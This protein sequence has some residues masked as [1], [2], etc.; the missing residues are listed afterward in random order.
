MP[1]KA[2]GIVTCFFAQENGYISIR[3]LADWKDPN[4]PGKDRLTL[5]MQDDM[6]PMARRSEM[7]FGL[8]FPTDLTDA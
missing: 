2:S 3:L 7:L 6:L 8:F 1:V 4:C 5:L